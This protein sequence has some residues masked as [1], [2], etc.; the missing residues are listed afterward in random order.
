M[1]PPHRVLLLSYEFTHSPFSGNGVLARSI[2][3]ALLKC[4]LAVRCVCSRPTCAGISPDAPIAPP[5]VTD[6]QAGALAVW[7]VTLSPEDG[8]KRVDRECAW[9]KFAEGAAGFSADVAAF[10]PQ[11]CIAVDWHGAGAWRALSA[12][13]AALPRLLYINFRFYS[14]G[15][16]EESAWYTPQ[17][18]HALE[19]AAAVLALSARDQAS[20][21]AL[22][23]TAPAPG[24]LLPPL[25]GDVHALA[26]SDAPA[27]VMPEAAAVVA[28]AAGAGRRCFLSCV[29]RLSPEKDPLL[30]AKLCAALGAERLGAL[31][32]TPLLCG[33]ASDASYAQT[34]RET[35]L[36][37]VPTAVVVDSFL[38]PAALGAIFSRT[39][40]NVHPCGYDAY[41]M[42][43]VEAAAFGSPSLVNGGGAVGATSLLGADGALQ[44]SLETLSTT[45]LAETVLAALAE[46]QRLTAVAAVARER[47]LGYDEEACGRQILEHLG[48]VGA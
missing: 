26:L 29:V 6:E 24:L 7:A 15:A 4:G 17:E 12:A 25:R 47:A 11:A 38:G 39:A 42:T 14:S 30:F 28:A 10:S 13:G 41:G 9:E 5:E 19:T 23:E 36:A 45:E 16:P 22:S 20:L 21:R 33:A 8:W 37:A 43:L 27:L 3:T 44:V 1:V 18:V 32:I 2:A 31:G 35:L 48:A 34:V 40:L 46:P